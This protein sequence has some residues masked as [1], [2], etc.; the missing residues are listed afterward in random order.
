[1]AFSVAPD[2][3]RWPQHTGGHQSRRSRPGNHPPVRHFAD[4]ASA[5]RA[6]G[7]GGDR[8]G[9]RA[10]CQ[11]RRRS[12]AALYPAT[13]RFLQHRGASRRPAPGCRYAGSGR[14]WFVCATERGVGAASCVPR[15]RHA[16]ATAAAPAAGGRSAPDR[17][18]G[19]QGGVAR[20]QAMRL[21]LCGF[22]LRFS[23]QAQLHGG[24]TDEH[25]S[26]DASSPFHQNHYM[27]SRLFP[28]CVVAS[29]C[30][31]ASATAG[32]RLA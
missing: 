1:M 26:L 17:Q 30:R 29:P 20:G 16:R 28:S 24:W 18:P 25:G 2:Q 31:T 4:A 23:G 22:K 15:R 3:A 12:A 13:R 6:S 21:S 8:A 19:Q 5:A 11:T 10:S 14:L 7:A 32:L 9:G 27:K